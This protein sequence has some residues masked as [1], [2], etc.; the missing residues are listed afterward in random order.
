MLLNG[1]DL[2]GTDLDY[3]MYVYCAYV[4][5]HTE[6]IKLGHRSSCMQGPPQ[7]PKLRAF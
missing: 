2:F 3:S 5:M 1:G 4:A 6:N 7:G